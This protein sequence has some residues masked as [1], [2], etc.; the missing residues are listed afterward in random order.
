MAQFAKQKGV[1][2][3]FLSWEQATTTGPHTPPTWEAQQSPWESRSPAPLRST[4]RHGTTLNSLDGSQRPGPTGSCWRHSAP[5]TPALLRDLRAGLGRRV[6]L[7]GGEDFLSDFHVAGPAALGMYIA[8][9]GADI[10]LLPPAG[11]RFLKELKSPHRQAEPVLHRL[12]R[13]VSRDPARRD[14]PLRRHPR[15]G[16]QG[17]VQDESR[18]RHPRRHPLRQ[19]RRPRRSTRHHLA[20]RTPLA[21][22]E[23]LGRRPSRHRP[24]GTASLRA[25]SRRPV[26]QA[27]LGVRMGIPHCGYAAMGSLARQ[28][29]GSRRLVSR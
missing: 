21:R 13:P 27:L 10:S 16:H 20:H 19:E 4:R 12:R 22:T 18:E 23:R 3:L 11:K 24:S 28:A 29:G 14:R 6:T 25:D 17:V 1:K 2:R 5:S 15:L 9:P 8:F 26:P 7:I